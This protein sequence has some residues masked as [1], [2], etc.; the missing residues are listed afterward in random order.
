[1]RELEEKISDQEEEL[2][3]QAG[4]KLV[5]FYLDKQLVEPSYQH[6]NDTKP[7]THEREI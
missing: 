3:E 1:M 5:Y 7:A 6:R 2:D 4:T